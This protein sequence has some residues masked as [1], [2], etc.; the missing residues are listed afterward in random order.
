MCQRDYLLEY[1]KWGAERE[2]NPVEPTTTSE[3]NK[4]STVETSDW[5]GERRWRKAMVLQTNQN[6]STAVDRSLKS[7]IQKLQQTNPDP[8]P[9]V[10]RRHPHRLKKHV[11]SSSTRIL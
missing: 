1:H 6:N 5:N 8:Y 11:I 4:R 10:E 7:P 3:A 2:S 9:M